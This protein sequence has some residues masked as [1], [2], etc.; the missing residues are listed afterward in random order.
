MGEREGGDRREKKRY[1]KIG[2]W[3]GER[4]EQERSVREGG[5]VHSLRNLSQWTF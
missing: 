5:G 1:G 4:L 3:A 2:E